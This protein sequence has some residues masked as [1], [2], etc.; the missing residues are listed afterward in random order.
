MG[1][2]HHT[3]AKQVKTNNNNLKEYV[4]HVSKGGTQG[5]QLE[6]LSGCVWG[7]RYVKSMKVDGYLISHIKSFVGEE[8][9]SNTDRQKVPY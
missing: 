8:M 9:K 1:H 4:S 3:H 7:G 6:P 5:H 2:A